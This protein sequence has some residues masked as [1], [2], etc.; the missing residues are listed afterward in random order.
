MAEGSDVR[1]VS[2]SRVFFPGQVIVI[3]KVNTDHEPARSQELWESRVIGVFPNRLVVSAP[4]ENGSP[5][6]LPER[7]AVKGYMSRYGVR[8]SFEAVVTW[9]SASLPP[10]TGLAA[11]TNIRKTDRRETVRTGLSIRP[12][13]FAIEGNPA[14]SAFVMSPVVDDISAGGFGLSC[15]QEIAVRSQVR[16]ALDLPKVFGRI[17]ASGEV[18]RVENPIRDLMGRWRWQMGLAFTEISQNDR[19]RVAAFVLFEQHRSKK[20]NTE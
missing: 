15:L 8:H 20:T 19:N 1:P 13:Y 7:T 2:L 14:K 17:Q 3:E 5:V 12:D 4:V 18:L 6:V 11:I 10:V 9:Q 16:V